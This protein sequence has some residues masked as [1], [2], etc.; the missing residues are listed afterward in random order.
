MT[1]PPDGLRP[2]MRSTMSKLSEEELNVCPHYGFKTLVYVIAFFHAIIQDR[3]KYGK[4]GWNVNYDFNE[5]DFKISYQLLNLYLT[6]AYNQKDETIPWASLKYLIGDAM[7]G[8]R[9][10]DD[11]D[12]RVLTNYLEEYMGDFL[13]DKV[14]LSVPHTNTYIHINFYPSRLY[15]VVARM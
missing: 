9:V 14:S 5:S 3:R 10:T 15:R 11:Y 13:F 6:K 12:R 2:N 8:G 4:I 1:E 7:Y